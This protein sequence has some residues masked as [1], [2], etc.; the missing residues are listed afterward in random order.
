MGRGTKHGGPQ[1]CSARGAPSGDGRVEIQALGRYEILAKIASGGMGTVYL[2]RLG[3]P[4]LERLYAIKRL[5]PHLAEEP[6]FVDMFVDEARLAARIRHP[7]VVSILE[8]GKDEGSFFLVMD[9]VQG[10]TPAELAV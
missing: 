7:N 1:G 10:A 6:E 5:H 3:R 9:Y 2:G 8:I 4:G